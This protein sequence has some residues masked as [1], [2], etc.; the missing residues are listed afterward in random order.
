MFKLVLI[1]FSIHLFLLLAVYDTFFQSIIE[2]DLPSTSTIKNPPAKRVLLIIVDGLRAQAIFEENEY[3][4]PFLTSIRKE[5]GSWGVSHGTA[6]TESRIGHTAVVAGFRE[7]PRAILNAWG[8]YPVQYDSVFEQSSNSWV[9]A[10][11]ICIEYVFAR[12]KGENVRIYSYSYPLKVRNGDIWSI[13]NFTQ[14]LHNKNFQKEFKIS[15]NIFAL[16]LPHLDKV[17][18][19]LL[20]EYS[21]EIKDIDNRIQNVTTIFNEVFPDNDTTFIVTSDHGMRSDFGHGT[22]TIMETS[23][24]FVCWGAGINKDST[25]KDV[26]N[27]DIAPLISV[28]LGIN[29]P[30]NSRGIVPINYLNISRE[31]KYAVLLKNLRQILNI[32]EK[33]NSR[34]S[35]KTMITQKQV[36]LQEVKR[37]LLEMETANVTVTNRTFSKIHNS[38]NTVLEGIEYI[39]LYYIYN[40]IFSVLLGLLFWILYLLSLFP[41]E[42]SE[43]QQKYLDSKLFIILVLFYVSSNFFALHSNLFYFVYYSFPLGSFSLLMSNHNSFLNLF[44]ISYK[45]PNKIFILLFICIYISIIFGFRER[46][47]FS[48]TFLLMSPILYVSPGSSSISSESWKHVWALLCTI[49]T[50]FSFTPFQSTEKDIILVL[51]GG[52]LWHLFS[53][54]Y[55]FEF[56]VIKEGINLTTSQYF[57]TLLQNIFSCLALT[58]RVYKPRLVDDCNFLIFLVIIPFA[59]IPF[60]IK[61]SELRIYTIFL[62]VVPTFIILSFPQDLFIFTMFSMLLLTYSIVETNISYEQEHSRYLK[63]CLIVIGFYLFCLFGIMN[64]WD[65]G[66]PLPHWLRWSPFLARNTWMI[67]EFYGIKFLIPL[68]I[69]ACVYRYIVLKTQLKLRTCFIISEIFFSIMMFQVILKVRNTGSWLEMGMSFINFVII[70]SFALFLVISYFV[71]YVFMETELPEALNDKFLKLTNSVY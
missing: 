35:T 54:Y 37:M 1:S 18:H 68:L 30:K 62:G 57:I 7:D 59:L 71:A 44:S 66:H 32:Y 42:L 27:I 67:Y 58:F 61:I 31:D 12:Y 4:A 23:S 24:P 40:S 28:L 38:I 64:L 6:P 21:E 41:K 46:Y 55:F 25:R 15:G 70:N 11:E 52:V 3:T 9:V 48:L 34:L 45:C 56:I 69:T 16:M 17:A 26:E 65:M 29:L 19:Q 53:W 49:L 50:W 63:I 20:R 14:L 8:H 13:N 33:K 43:T 36:N 51:T 22:D 5:K 47:I 10:G 2:T 39:Q 60:S